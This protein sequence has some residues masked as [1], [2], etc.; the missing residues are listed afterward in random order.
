MEAV[1]LSSVYWHEFEN[2]D[3]AISARNAA[4]DLVT[5]AEIQQQRCSNDIN[6]AE[7]VEINLIITRII[8]LT[9]IGLDSTA[10]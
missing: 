10:I 9:F 4:I 8:L 2:M 7:A 1:E 5:N 3:D 6:E